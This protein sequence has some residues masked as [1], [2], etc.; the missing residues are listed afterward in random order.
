[1]TA[2]R[3]PDRWQRLGGEA[4][5]FLLGGVSTTLVSYAVYLLLLPHLAYL[6][7]YAIA[8]A[9]GIA[10][11]YFANTLFVFRRKPSVKRALAFPLVYAAQYAVGSVLLVVL[12]DRLRIPAQLGPLLVVILTLPLTYIAS[13]W[14]ITTNSPA[15]SAA[16]P[17][18][19][20]D[21]ASPVARALSDF[22]RCIPLWADGFIA[23]GIA[24][25]VALYVFMSWP[26][27]LR[28]PIAMNGDA[29]S[30]LYI[31]KSILEHGTYLQ[32]PD[33]GAPFGATMYDYPIP[34]PTHHLLIRLIGLFT[35]DPF[36]AFDVFYLLSFATAAFTACWAFGRNGVGRLPA[37]AGA[38][39]FALVPYHFL[40]VGHIFLASY[41]AIPVLCHYAL[42]LATYRAP[43]VAG[44]PRLRWPSLLA[45]ALAAGTGVYYAFF[46]VLFIALGGALGF[47]R[48]HYYQPLRTAAVYAAVI[49]AVVALSLLPN[50]LYHLSEGGNAMI[51]HRRPAEAEFYG[52][53]IT[54]LLFP[55]P[56]HRIPALDTFMVSYRVT[57]PNVNENSTAALGVIGSIGFLIAVIA[58]FSGKARRYPALWSTGA[59]CVAGVLYATLGGFG[60]IVARLAIP[61]LRGLNRISVFIAFFALYAFFIAAR[62]LIGD[63]RTPLAN[64]AL[65]LIVVSIAC[66]DQIPA[67][68]IPKPSAPRFAANKVFFDRVQATFPA[69]TAFFELPYIYFPESPTPPSSYPLLEPYLLT[70]GF[71]WSFGEMHRRPADMWNEQVSEL[72]GSDLADALVQAGFGAIFVDRR[73]NDGAV[74]EKKVRAQFGPPTLEDVAGGYAVYRVTPATANP[75]PFIVADLGRG[76]RDWEKGKSVGDDVAWSNGDAD[77]VVANPAGVAIPFVA[78][79]KLTTLVPRKVTLAYGEQVLSSVQL[80]P[81]QSTDMT[82]SFDAQAGISRLSMSTDVPAQPVA[83]NE[84][85]NRAFRIEDLTYGPAMTDYRAR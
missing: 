3:L 58:F 36:V 29:T 68:G 69:G 14:I 4:V 20:D 19:F 24:L 75:M 35:R 63:R 82:A 61:E 60:A 73:Y 38:I 23:A 59:L 67:H 41:A 79:F 48:S 33:V 32:N 25:G 30:A 17:T 15:T 66:F 74:A 72:T 84:S 45:L 47:A 34:E 64:V 80:K 46:G 22:S 65:V 6:V 21:S 85:R 55:T 31:F 8:Y 57:S 18:R 13:R 7:A 81:G 44:M 11:S 27:D 37:I 71:R 10:W 42:Q 51:A 16:M 1:V 83:D 77:L 5:R 26:L 2:P 76:W 54:Q 62:Q 49:V 40:R 28:I 12:I 78:R 50:V 53:R 70:Q 56:G 43:H 39:T 9:T 52:L